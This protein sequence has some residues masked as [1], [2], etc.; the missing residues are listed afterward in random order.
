MKLQVQNPLTFCLEEYEIP[1][2][3][4]LPEAPPPPKLPPPPENPP[5]P[6]PTITILF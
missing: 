2:V 6:P 1:H 3:Y 4:Q 5:K